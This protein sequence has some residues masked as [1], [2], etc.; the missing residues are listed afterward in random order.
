MNCHDVKTRL[1]HPGDA[2]DDGLT[3]D[4]LAHLE[5]CANCTRYQE[6]LAAILHPSSVLP[7]EI[8]P[9]SDLWP[10]IASRLEAPEG[11]AKERKIWR[12][13]YF[14]PLA[15][16]AG[17]AAILATSLFSLPSRQSKVVAKAPIETAEITPNSVAARLPADTVEIG[18]ARTRAVLMKR[19]EAQKSSAAPEQ[20]ALLEQSLSTMDSA[21][22]DIQ[23]ALESD[24]YNASLLFKLSHARRRELRLLQQVV[25]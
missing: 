20:I 9:P 4:V 6:R 2:A 1:D 7:R 17:I 23:A 18:F 24:P 12:L 19:L 22:Q 10:G 5:D 21:V 11:Q 8:L 16:A 15:A 25:L 3:P 14:F 13:P